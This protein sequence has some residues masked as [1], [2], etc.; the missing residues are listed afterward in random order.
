MRWVVV[1]CVLAAC[2]SDDPPGECTDGETRACYSGPPG[3]EGVG[4]CVAG[5]DTCSG[6]T[7]S[8]ICVGDIVPF[9]EHCDGRDEDC[10][11]TVDDA[12]DSGA[13]CVAS[14]GCD[15]AMACADG[16]VTC[17][18]PGKNECGVCAGVEVANLGAPCVSADCDGMLVCNAAG[19]GT[20]CNAP[21][22][23][24]C[25]LCGGPPVPGLGD[26]C[27]GSNTCAGRL[28]CNA[29]NNGSVCDCSE[30]LCN[31]N[32]TLRPI[33]VAAEG[34]LVITEV[35]P[36]PT[37]V[38]DAAGE[39]FEVRVMR[40]LDLNGIA[41]DRAGDTTAPETIVAFDCIPIAAGSTLVFAK[42]ADPAANGGI[43]GGVTRTFSFALIDG[44]AA[45]PGDVQLLAGATVVDA[46]S[47][48]STRSGRTHQ[49]DPDLTDHIANNSEAAFCDGTTPY[50]LGDFGTPNAA[51]VQCPIV[52]PAGSCDDGGSIR[53]IVKPAAGA[54]VISEVMVNPVIESP[55]GQE[56]FEIT[57]TGLAPFDVNELGLDQAAGTRP[58]DIIQ[59]TACLSIPPGGF[60][61]FA[62]TVDPALNGGIT[63]VDATFGFALSN[64]AGDLQVVDGANVLDAITW[65]NVS[66]GSFDGV[67]LALDPDAT[68]TAGN[69]T[70]ASTL[71]TVWCLGSSPYGDG[72][73]LG[74]P[75]A[76]NAQCP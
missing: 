14:D 69:D 49:L 61:V 30:N 70:P 60:A 20:T 56:W 17:V 15:G 59:N 48:T 12:E 40:D 34:D 72:T 10:N 32:G 63:T 13:A 3:T 29:A 39:W 71:G 24:E 41:L 21:A 67:S 44:S 4:T 7:F 64:T 37:Q 36:N 18:S 1:V 25:T 22:A 68:T 74:T 43:T 5:V 33:V 66:A 52:V 9:V 47:W 42:T 11:G 76:A 73:N 23:N 35:M 57:N 26:T 28:A 55:A 54:L 65:G 2:G 38:A 27:M 6:G 31:D 8:G 45:A 50:G 58:P 51:N 16:A 75:R 46:I 62:R 53:P 19:D